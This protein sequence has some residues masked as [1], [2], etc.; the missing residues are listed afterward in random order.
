MDTHS[1]RDAR[2]PDAFIERL[3]QRADNMRARGESQITGGKTGEKE[4]GQWKENGIYIRKLPDD[5]Q[6]ILRISVGGG[7]ADV[8]YCTFRG[9]R[10]ACMGLLRRAL[11]ALGRC[12]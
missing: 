10:L 7:I 11:E 4:L 2:L 9:D 3:T 12:V 8:D 6:S 1:D 5:E